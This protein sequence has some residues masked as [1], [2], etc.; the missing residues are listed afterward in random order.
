VRTDRNPTPTTASCPPSR[1]ATWNFPRRVDPGTGRSCRR[2]EAGTGAGGDVKEEHRMKQYLLSVYQ[3]DG[4]PPP[5]EMLEPIM[6]AVDA[7]DRE[8]RAAGVW[9]FAGAL[10]SPD[11][12]TVVRVADGDVLTTDG[13]YAEG[14]EHLGGFTVVKVPDLDAALEWARKFA[15][16]TT[17]PVEVR[18]F[19][20]GAGD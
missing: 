6:R 20:G 13:P 19:Q 3:P 15:R 12:A 2:W 5:P 17:L 9:V 11:T 18:P 7:V 16:A 10:H 1:A 14:K 8:A 4:E